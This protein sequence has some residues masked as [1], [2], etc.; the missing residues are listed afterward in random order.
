[1]GRPGGRSVPIHTPIKEEPRFF[2][3]P[4][5]RGLFIPTYSSVTRLP[6]S[7]DFR[8]VALRPRLSTGLPLSEFSYGFILAGQPQLINGITVLRSYQP[9]L[10]RDVER[11]RY[12]SAQ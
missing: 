5:K 10:A 2:G 12:Q 6:W 3:Q 9:L 7:V 1:M 11:L 4:K 8:P